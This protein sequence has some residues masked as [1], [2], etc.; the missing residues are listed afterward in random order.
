M[1]GHA[2]TGPTP[3]PPRP[4]VA[5]RCRSLQVSNL[6]VTHS[7][8][9]QIY[10]SQSCN[11]DASKVTIANS[12][13]RGNIAW[14][15][16][17]GWCGMSTTHWII[18]GSNIHN[19]TAHWGG[20]GMFAQDASKITIANSSVLRHD[21]NTARHSGGGLCGMDTLYPCVTHWIITDGS[22]IHNNTAHW[23]GGGM[24]AGNTHSWRSVSEHQ[25]WMQCCQ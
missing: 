21:G 17:G 19:N 18:T 23:A 16:G 10:C 8:R 9:R 11:N 2:T 22:S 4:L 24:F 15:H 1:W 6:C 13:V 14:K 3:L 20:G 7:R 12:S 25:R 5:V